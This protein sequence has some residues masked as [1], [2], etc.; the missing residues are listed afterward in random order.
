MMKDLR[1]Y[2]NMRQFSRQKIPW[3][4]GLP[5]LPKVFFCR[6]NLTF[7]SKVRKKSFEQFFVPS[8]LVCGIN[9]RR[10]DKILATDHERVLK[11]CLYIIRNL[12]F[13]V[14]VMHSM[15]VKKV[16]MIR[17]TLPKFL[18]KETG[19]QLIFLPCTM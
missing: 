18:Q 12:H 13:S 17:L 7:L 16:K 2:N 1:Y 11:I 9:N 5:T 15:S 14:A 6:S 19:T 3:V 10:T 4:F 8:Y